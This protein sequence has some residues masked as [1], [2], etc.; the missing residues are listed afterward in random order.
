MKPTQKSE[1]TC[2]G[3]KVEL[4]TDIPTVSKKMFGVESE[5]VF[6]VLLR[7]TVDSL[8]STI[9]KDTSVNAVIS[10]LQN[11]EPRDSMEAM[12]VAQMIATHSHAMEWSRRAVLPEQTER[13]IEMN[14]SRSTRLMRTFT[15]QIEALQKYRKKGKQTIQVQHVNIQSGGQAIVGG[16]EGGGG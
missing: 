13:C 5:D 9:D 11:L 1:I 4:D 7:Q 6:A 2:K 8:P 3:G 16:I 10:M 14:V 15:S 12:L